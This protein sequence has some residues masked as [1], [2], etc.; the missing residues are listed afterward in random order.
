M[1]FVFPNFVSA[2]ST[3]TLVN[4]SVQLWPEYDQPSMLVITDFEVTAGAS[5]PATLTFRIPSDANLIAVANYTADG[6]LANAP[7]EG[8]TDDGEWQSFTVTLDSRAGRFEYYQP[9]TRNGEQRLFSYL[10]DGSYAV[11]AFDIR[12]LEPLDVSLLVTTPKLESIEQQKELKYFRGEPVKLAAGEQFA[13]NLE[14]KKT[15]D[16]LIASPQGVQPV[17]PVDEN[18]PGRVSLNNTLPYLIG[19]LGVIL[20]VGGLVYYLKSDNTGGK[21]SRAKRRAIVDAE[22][23][24]SGVYCAQCGT[25]ARAGDRFCRTCGAR[26]RRQEE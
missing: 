26:L 3:P 13:L 11:D 1:F 14:Y 22:E 5:L 2:Q 20:I 16:A 6:N 10:W 18:T 15:S 19:G 25:R 8:P 12:V 21:K 24:E 4:V 17:A 23:S 7:F 9:L